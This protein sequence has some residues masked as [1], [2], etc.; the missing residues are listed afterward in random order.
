MTAQIINGREIAARIQ[1][2]VRSVYRI[3]SKLRE[4]LGVRTSE[5]IVDAARKR[6]LL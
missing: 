5:Q 3:R 2:V 4:H 1:K 6:G